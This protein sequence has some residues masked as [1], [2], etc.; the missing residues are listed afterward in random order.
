M[1]IKEGADGA[2]SKQKYHMSIN[3]KEEK[4]WTEEMDIQSQWETGKERVAM[5]HEF[6]ALAG[7]STYS[8]ASVLQPPWI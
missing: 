6:G 7:T 1:V 4:K 3:L 5:S 8:L 2:L